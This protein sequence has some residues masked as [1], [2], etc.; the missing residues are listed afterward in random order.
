MQELTCLDVEDRRDA[1]L[2]ADM[3]AL[4]GM[5]DARIAARRA[6]AYRLDAQAVVGGPPGPE[7]NAR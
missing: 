7:P 4:D 6:I 5:G 2:C 3:S 1:E